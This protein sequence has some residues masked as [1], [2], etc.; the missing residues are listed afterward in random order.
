MAHADA[1]VYSRRPDVLWRRSLD[2]VVLLPAG[3]EDPVTLPGTGA[4]VWDLLAAPAT[5]PELVGTLVE[6]YGEDP[7]TVERDV[8]ALLDRLARIAAIDAA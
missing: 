1:P 8:A 2:A 3:C 4:A 7:V 5:L 6:V